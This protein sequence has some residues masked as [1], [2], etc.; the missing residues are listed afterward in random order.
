M[1]SHQRYSDIEWRSLRV[2]INLY[3][4]MK[5]QLLLQMKLY[6]TQKKEE[7]AKLISESI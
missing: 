3:K 7:L 5:E 1:S 4:Q 6:H 2:R